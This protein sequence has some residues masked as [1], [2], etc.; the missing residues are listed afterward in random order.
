VLRY[1]GLRISDAVALERDQ[2]AP[3][4]GGTY[5]HALYCH[6][7]KTRTK[8][9]A[10]FVHIPVPCGNL[11]GHPNLAEALLSLP[12][13]NGRYFFCGGL[14]KMR[15][16]VTSWRNRINRLFKSAARVP[17]ARGERFTNPPHPHRFR[18]T[19]AA[20]LLQ[21]GV[22]LR[23]VAQYLGDTEDIVRKHY[24]KFCLAEQR[25]A[26]EVLEQAVRRM[27]VKEHTRRK[28]ELKVVTS[29]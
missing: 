16:N 19:F 29:P 21:N 24:A 8:R 14:G 17:A 23:V 20:T 25:E 7:K 27:V 1:T 10:N 11:P 15:T 22:P 5:T 6:P 28:R 18:H 26:A 3:F 2:L 9:S 12:L 13:K 4:E